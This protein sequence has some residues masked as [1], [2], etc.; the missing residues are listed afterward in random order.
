LVYPGE[1]EEPIVKGKYLDK[2]TGKD[3]DEMECSTISLKVN[4]DINKWQQV[5][6]RAVKE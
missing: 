3:I 5:I 2:V 1:L 4:E 6:F